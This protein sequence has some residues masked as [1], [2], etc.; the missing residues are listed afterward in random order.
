MP[1]VRSSCTDVRRRLPNYKALARD[2]P[3]NSMETWE[4]YRYQ[5][6]AD[7]MPC[8]VVPLD[9]PGK[10][11]CY[12]PTAHSTRRRTCKLLV[13]PHSPVAP[14]FPPGL[15]LYGHPSFTGH[16]FVCTSLDSLTFGPQHIDTRS[17]PPLPYSVAILGP[18]IDPSTQLLT[19][20]CIDIKVFEGIDGKA[21]N[22]G[23]AFIGMESGPDGID[24]LENIS[25]VPTVDMLGQ[26]ISQLRDI[27]PTP[28]I[29]ATSNLFWMQRSIYKATDKL[30]SSIAAIHALRDEAMTD[31]QFLRKTRVMMRCFYEMALY[32]RRWAG[33][34][35]KLPITSM[36]APV[37]DA[38]NPISTKLLNKFAVAS[39]TGVKMTQNGNLPAGLLDEYGMLTTM[40]QLCGESVL[41]I[42]DTLPPNQQ[43]IL[44]NATKLGYNFQM[45]DGSGY[46]LLSDEVNTTDVPRNGNP[47]DPFNGR[48]F[49][50]NLF[51]MYFGSPNNNLRGFIAQSSVQG[52][53]GYCV[54]IAANMAG[55]TV[56]TIIQ[57]LYRT[58]PLWAA[59][60]G[61]WKNLHT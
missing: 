55:R 48:P 35:R 52:T 2:V 59:A 1:R 42:Y 8:S 38:T 28:D 54:Q 17:A 51:T 44:K 13:D 7:D 45:I 3:K 39:V 31:P 56:Q 49:S 26:F 61:P 4:R 41:H 21:V 47:A 58:R 57:N 9:Q 34:D 18:Y 27:A 29:P 14:N 15:Y 11:T 43:D 30:R 23:R 19:I 46:W 5:Q 60:E 24:V 37:Q 20:R 10:T 36:P 25:P 53:H 6:G 12:A 22:L 40:Q 16:D 33:P 32:S 50:L